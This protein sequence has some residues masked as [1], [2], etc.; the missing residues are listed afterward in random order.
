MAQ[1]IQHKYNMMHFKKEVQR[2]KKTEVIRRGWGFS[3]LILL[4]KALQGRGNSTEIWK[5]Y[6]FNIRRLYTYKRLSGQHKE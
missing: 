5:I 3:H 1:I 2:R 4:R 6:I